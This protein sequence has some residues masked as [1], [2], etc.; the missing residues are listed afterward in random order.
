MLGI[1]AG[2]GDVDVALYRHLGPLLVSYCPVKRP[3][4][5]IP[6]VMLEYAFPLE[7]ADDDAWSDL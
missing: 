4:Q 6:L 1:V 7:P 2:R 5:G 3:F